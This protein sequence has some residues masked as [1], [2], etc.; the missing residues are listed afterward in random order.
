MGIQGKGVD[1]SGQTLEGVDKLFAIRTVTSDNFPDVERA[2]KSL[3]VAASAA[4]TPTEGSRAADASSPSDAAILNSPALK[5]LPPGVPCKNR[6]KQ[7]NNIVITQPLRREEENPDLDR[8]NAT[9]VDVG[10]QL[11]GASAP[12]PSPAPGAPVPTP[13]QAAAGGGGGA[14]GSILAKAE[15]VAKT[16]AGDRL[17]AKQPASKTFVPKKAVITPED[18]YLHEVKFPNGTAEA[19]VH[20]FAP[21][22]VPLV[23]GKTAPAKSAAV[24]GKTAP[25]KSA[26]IEGKT[27]AESFTLERG[28]SSS[29]VGVS[30]PSRKDAPSPPPARTEP[31]VLGA[32]DHLTASSSPTSNAHVHPPNPPT[33]SHPSTSTPSPPA[34][35]AHRPLSSLAQASSHDS[36]SR[37]FSH[38]LADRAKLA[39]DELFK[40]GE[41]NSPDSADLKFIESVCKNEES[42]SSSKTTCCHYCQARR[43]TIL[44][45]FRH[46]IVERVLKTQK[47]LTP[48]QGDAVFV[49]QCQWMH[50][51]GLFFVRIVEEKSS[52]LIMIEKPGVLLWGVPAVSVG[53]DGVLLWGVPSLIHTGELFFPLRF[54][55]GPHA[56]LRSRPFGT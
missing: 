14:A 24:E 10:Q 42:S 40:T 9:V 37:Y 34:G 49:R 36:S 55:R 25:T 19:G 16:S 52:D 56:G 41:V 6:N 38:S 43:P 48:A 3:N 53:I 22:S 44:A 13:A 32:H 29:P 47:R 4:L 21:K 1:G 51:W 12:V 20:K 7:K 46:A 54:D 23:E 33:A 17:L 5:P 15:Q 26:A 45:N 50:R 31:A 35:A 2:Q 28:G 39:A 27:A 8:S 18:T 11:A 30:S